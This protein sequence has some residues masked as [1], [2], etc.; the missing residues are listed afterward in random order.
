MVNITIPVPTNKRI[1]ASAGW[2][3]DPLNDL[4]GRRGV[5]FLAAVFSL[6][7]PFGMALSQTWG[8]LAASRYAQIISESLG[9][10][11]FLIHERT[12][13]YLELEWG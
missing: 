6:V 1:V 12:A 13:C 11:L 8:Q 3:S 10:N 2:A 7:A 4:M 9:R 5:I